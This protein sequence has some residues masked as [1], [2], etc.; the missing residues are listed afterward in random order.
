MSNSK[1][2]TRISKNAA[3]L[4]K[5]R[6]ALYEGTWEKYHAGT[7]MVPKGQGWPGE[8]KSYLSDYTYDSQTE[9]K[10]SE[11]YAACRAHREREHAEEQY[12]QSFKSQEVRRERF[13]PDDDAKQNR[14][15][16]YKFVACGFNK[17]RHNAG[18]LEQVSEHQ[19]SEKRQ[20]AGKHDTDDTRNDDREHYFFL[21][22]HGT[23]L[24]HADFAFLF[25]RQQFHNRRLDNGNERH[26]TVR[27]DCDWPHKIGCE[28]GRYVDCRNIRRDANDKAKAMKKNSEMTED[29]MKQSDKEIQDLTD[30]Y[31]KQIDAVTANKSKEIME[32]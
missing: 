32:I 3:L 2:K 21:F 15:D 20:C 18:F 25:R 31:V 23:K 11:Q 12:F 10:F 13:C 29:E 8:G 9:I 30:K 17:A 1:A 27:R 14:N 16:V 19:H 24:F 22:R 4:L 6:V 7:A 5:S 26:I 28:P